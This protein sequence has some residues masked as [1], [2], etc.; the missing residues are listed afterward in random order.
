MVETKYR[1]GRGD[2][3]RIHWA[4]RPSCDEGAKSSS[5]TV[6]NPTRVVT[7]VH[8]AGSQSSGSNPSST[9]EM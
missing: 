7:T 3:P 9:E 6:T 5:E 8:P 2:G 4:L 1:D